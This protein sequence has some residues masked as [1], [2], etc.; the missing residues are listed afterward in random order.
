M[1]IMYDKGASGSVDAEISATG[2]TGEPRNEGLGSLGENLDM[3][4]GIGDGL[5]G[6]CG[7]GWAGVLTEGARVMWMGNMDSQIVFCI[8]DIVLRNIY[9][10][11]RMKR[12]KDSGVLGHPSRLQG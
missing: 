7:V 6:A 8:C 4:E 12:R 10:I 11:G 9:C 2:G 3:L 5:G 1:L